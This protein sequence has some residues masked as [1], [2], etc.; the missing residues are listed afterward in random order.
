MVGFHISAFSEE[1][2]VF[3]LGLVPFGRFL[4][5]LFREEQAQRDVAAILIGVCL[6][7]RDD[8]FFPAKINQDGDSQSIGFGLG[9]LGLQT[10]IENRQALFLAAGRAVGFSQFKVETSGTEQVVKIVLE[11][12]SSLFISFSGLVELVQ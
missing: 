3:F 12:G 4:G 9:W 6:Q 7:R 1:G 2:D 10:L 11:N 5:V 8:F